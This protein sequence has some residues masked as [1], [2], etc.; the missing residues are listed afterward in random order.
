MSS[1]A[2]EAI[3]MKKLEQNSAK[4][5]ITLRMNGKKSHRLI[6]HAH[7]VASLFKKTSAFMP[8]GE[9]TSRE[10]PKPP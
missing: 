7:D 9:L 8:F 3:Q 10:K 5:M 4:N 6:L 2:L 1:I